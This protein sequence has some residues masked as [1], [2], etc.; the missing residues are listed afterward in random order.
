MQNFPTLRLAFL[1]VLACASLAACSA[2]ERIVVQTRFI[3]PVLPPALTARCAAPVKLP[4]RALV[5]GEIVPLWGKDRAALKACAAR[6]GAIVE[7][8]K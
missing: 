8:V 1:T 6:H 2:P 7:A 5:A 4:D 3:K